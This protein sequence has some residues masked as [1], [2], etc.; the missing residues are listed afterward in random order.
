MILEP[1]VIA[2][3]Q[4]VVLPSVKVTFPAGATGVT[5]DDAVSVTKSSVAELAGTGV[6]GAGSKA[7]VALAAVTVWPPDKDPALSPKDPSELR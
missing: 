5:G 3:V 2:V 6:E 4:S 1:T 7:S